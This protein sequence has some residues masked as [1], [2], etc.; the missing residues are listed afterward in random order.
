VKIKGITNKPL[1]EWIDYLPTET[2]LQVHRSTLVNIN[3]LKNIERGSNYSFYFYVVGG[4]SP[5]RLTFSTSTSGTDASLV[6]AASDATGLDDGSTKWVRVT[7][8]VNDGAGNRVH[9]FYLSDDGT[10]WT[11][12]GATITTAGTTSIADTTAGLEVAGAQTGNA[13]LNGKV[14]R[15]IIQNAFDTVDNTTNVVFDADFE[16]APVN[17]LSF[18][19]SSTNAATVSIRTSRYY[20]GLPNHHWFATTTG[21]NAANR[22]YYTPFNVMEAIKVDALRFS[23]TTGPSSAANVRCG[24]Y[25]SDKNG[26]PTGAPLIDTGNIS[27]AASTAGTGIYIK[28][29]S[30]TTLP[31]GRYLMAIISSVTM[32]LRLWRAGIAPLRSL[33]NTT[34]TSEIATV[35]ELSASTSFGALPNPPVRWTD[36]GSSTLMTN[37]HKVLLRYTSGVD[38]G[39]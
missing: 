14:H 22:M 19:E 20:Y 30:E 2:F 11:Q 33:I 31:P 5:G 21:S 28:Q 35:V 3:Y 36:V 6:T 23:V 15:V 34:T 10:S 17:A 32:T 27:V 13:V 1:R 4:G 39:S 24:V 8:D 12:L 7:L 38:N 26:Q 9:K 37:L 29:I 18:T 16:A 25:A